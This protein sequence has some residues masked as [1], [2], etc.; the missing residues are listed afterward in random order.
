MNKAFALLSLCALGSS[1]SAAGYFGIY[2]LGVQY[3]AESG[4]FDTRFGLGLPLV[5]G[6][7]AALSGNVALLSEGTPLGSSPRFTG[8]FGGGADVA[9][10]AAGSASGAQGGVAVRPNVLGG[11]NF[12]FG[13]GVNAFG[14]ASFGPTFVFAGGE[15]GTVLTTGLKF[16]VNFK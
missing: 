14:E 11:L 2:T 3:T 5:F 15:R 9:L 16:G 4:A 1:A 6:G 13:S 7:V 8:Y 10:V 12:D